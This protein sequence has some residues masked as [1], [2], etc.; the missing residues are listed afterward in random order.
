MF[1]PLSLQDGLPPPYHPP[2]P[3]LLASSS[4]VLSLEERYFL[5]A[6]SAQ[7]RLPRSRRRPVLGKPRMVAG[8]RV[9]QEWVLGRVQ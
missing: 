2:P 3:N 5:S 9:L 8:T 6:Q 4:E 7:T 1:F